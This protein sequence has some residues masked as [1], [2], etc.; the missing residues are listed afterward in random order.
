VNEL[1]YVEAVAQLARDLAAWKNAG[2][3]L[4]PEA[5]YQ[6]RLAVC[7]TCPHYHWF[8]CKKCSCFVFA[9]ARLKTA[10]CPGGYWPA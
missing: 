8:Q 3:A 7:K 9:K 4:M 10:A 5:G 6:A 2:F 1:G